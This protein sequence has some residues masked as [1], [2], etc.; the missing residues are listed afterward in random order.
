MTVTIFVATGT[1]AKETAQTT[2]KVTFSGGVL[3]ASN[4]PWQASLP[5]NGASTCFVIL[6]AQVDL[7]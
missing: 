7:P 5:A 6:T 3:N 4:L 2:V 1:Q